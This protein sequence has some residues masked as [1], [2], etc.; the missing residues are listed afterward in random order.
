MISKGSDVTKAAPD[1]F[2]DLFADFGRVAVRRFFGGEGVFA[3]EIMIG[4]VF[5]DRIYLKTDES[6]RKAY[7]AERTKPFTFKK[8][9][10]GETVVTGWYAVPERLYD[11][12]EEFAR[13]ARAAFDVASAS[14][15]AEKK[16]K[17]AAKR[18]R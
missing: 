2:A 10:T 6:T 8:R 5:D 15:T 11:E 17:K 4:M 12:P 1:R 7:L 3:G 13:W 16:R 14:P 9:S 18:P